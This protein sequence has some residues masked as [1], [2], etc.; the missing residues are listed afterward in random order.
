MLQAVELHKTYAVRQPGLTWRRREFHA[1]AGVSLS[2]SPGEALGLVGESGCGKS[3]LAR[4]LVGLVPPTRGQVLIGGRERMDMNPAEAG[5]AMREVQMV[6]QDPQSSL[7]PRKTVGSIVSDPLRWHGEDEDQARQTADRLLDT[8]KLGRA[9]RDRLP[10][11]LSGGQRQRVCVARAL[12]LGPRLLVLDEPLS[13]LDV[14]VQAHILNLLADLQRDLGLGLLLIS[15]D[16]HAVRWLCDRVAVMDQGRIVETGPT[17]AVLRD[18][19]HATT[20]RLLEA[21][22]KARHTRDAAITTTADQWTG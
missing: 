4:L 13:A 10:H 19:Q 6:F 17:E 22:P 3:T 15:H 12:A 2:V 21:M 20:R 7:N 5:R 1:V 8:V 14:S 16:L 9:F 11:T 18:P